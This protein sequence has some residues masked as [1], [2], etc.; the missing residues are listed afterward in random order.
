[1]VIPVPDKAQVDVLYGYAGGL[2]RSDPDFYAVDVLNTLLGAGFSSRL[3]ANVR[4]RL[5]LVYGIYSGTAATLGPGPF[6]VRLGSN[7]AN[8]D[9]AVAE[10]DRQLSML[11]E[12]GVTKDEVANAISYQTGIYAVRVATNA[13]VA[14]QLRDAEIY[15]LGLDYLEKRAALYRAVTVDQV[16]AAARKYLHPGMG[17]LVIAGTYTGKYAAAR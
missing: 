9:A 1:V 2:R 12:K 4:D 8:V 13:G 16:N 7:P 10:M 14:D 11:R 3:M 5:G 15:G 17:A 6:Q